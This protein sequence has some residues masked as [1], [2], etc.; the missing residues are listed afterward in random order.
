MIKLHFR[1]MKHIVIIPDNELS[2]KPIPCT[3]QVHPRC[4]GF[5]IPTSDQV[6]TECILC[7]LFKNRNF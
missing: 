4:H 7:S 5:F 1:T 2:V 6:Q 3:S